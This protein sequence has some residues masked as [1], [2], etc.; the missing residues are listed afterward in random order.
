M[1]IRLLMISFSLMAL[2]GSND[3][4]VAGGGAKSSADSDS[5]LLIEH[6]PSIQRVLMFAVHDAEQAAN[7]ARVTNTWREVLQN[8]P[9][10]IW[11]NELS[12]NPNALPQAARV[13][14]IVAVQGLLDA[15]ANINQADNDSYPPLHEAARHGHAEVVRLLL[16]AGAQVNQA[17]TY[18]PT[19]L[20]VAACN[21]HAEVVRLLLA[22]GAQVNQADGIG[23][24][25]LQVAIRHNH[26][27]IERMLRERGA[28]DP[29]TCCV[30][31]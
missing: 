24:T 11:T 15:G 5:N 13:G 3:V 1:L 12:R 21:G 28:A 20:G 2:A 6:I 25:P 23:G 26:T 22:E 10:D 4:P 18:G 8:C 9:G 17:S 7:L 30:V 14:N 27:E 19:P 29:C 31:Q 16:A